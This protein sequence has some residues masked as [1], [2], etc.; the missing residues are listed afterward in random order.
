MATVPGEAA[1]AGDQS[2]R[3]GETRRPGERA[4]RESRRRAPG[5]KRD[6]QLPEPPADRRCTASQDVGH[7]D[8]RHPLIDVETLQIPGVDGATPHVPW[9]RCALRLSKSTSGERYARRGEGRP[10]ADSRATRTQVVASRHQRQVGKGLPRPSYRNV[11]RLI[12]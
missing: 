1:V 8:G 4:G 10:Y 7:P 5:T 11:T 2:H 9:T 12:S 3:V 6:P